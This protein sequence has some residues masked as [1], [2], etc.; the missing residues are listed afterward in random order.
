M[1]KQHC[2]NG[3]YGSRKTEV[4]KRLAKLL[5]MN[6]VDTDTVI[7]AAVGMKIPDIF[8]KHG[9]EHFRSEEAAVIRKAA[10][11]NCCVIATGKC[12]T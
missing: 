3:L 7:E 11:N 10:D 12:R 4:G 2:F 1:K 6:F 9:E 5:K 8:Q